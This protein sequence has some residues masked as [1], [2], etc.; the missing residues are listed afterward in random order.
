MDHD[1]A[2]P[3]AGRYRLNRAWINRFRLHMVPPFQ[4][5]GLRAAIR[6]QEIVLHQNTHHT[7]LGAADS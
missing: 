6:L 3:L 4:A 5:T 2:K 1:H 7:R